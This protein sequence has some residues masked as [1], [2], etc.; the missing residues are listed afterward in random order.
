MKPSED[1]DAIEPG[2]LPSSCGSKGPT[3]EQDL[4]EM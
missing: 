4:D 2:S 3:G 1:V